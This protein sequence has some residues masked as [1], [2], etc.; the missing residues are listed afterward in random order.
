VTEA[1]RDDGD[2]SYRTQA[3]G[4]L[5]RK[6]S[7]HSEEVHVG[8]DV[9]E[10]GVLGL[11]SESS[12]VVLS[13]DGSDVSSGLEVKVNLGGVSGSG[14]SVHVSGGSGVKGFLMGVDGNGVVFGGMGHV[15]VLNGQFV[16]MLGFLPG[17]F[18]SFSVGYG[19]SPPVMGFMKGHMAV[20][21]LDLGVSV[22]LVVMGLVV[23]GNVQFFKG[24]LVVGFGVESGSPGNGHS[25]SG[26]L[27]GL[28]GGGVF[29]DPGVENSS[30]LDPDV[31]GSGFSVLGVEVSV[32]SL[33]SDLDVFHVLLHHLSLGTLG[34][35]EGI[36]VVEERHVAEH[37]DASDVVF[38]ADD[39]GVH[40]GDVHV[41]IGGAG[42]GTDATAVVEATGAG[43]INVAVVGVA[44]FVVVDDSSSGSGSGLGLGSFGIESRFAADAAVL[45]WEIPLR[46]E[47][48]LRPGPSLAGIAPDFGIICT[49]MLV[50][51]AIGPARR[52]DALGS[53]S[54]SG[55]GRGSGRGSASGRGRGSGSATQF[56][57]L[58]VHLHILG[59]TFRG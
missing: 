54:A 12:E 58:S 42:S 7:M 5:T 28:N 37:A 13:L 33:S 30:E 21:D 3:E 14:H 40:V 15:L 44:D 35:S 8:L 50:S 32:G 9:A 18:G 56:A 41:T 36:T 25:A 4:G 17:K 31:V 48:P 26:D 45:L 16:H 1:S 53:G 24:D 19:N 23:S 11:D 27:V 39:L 29:G 57:E 52:V 59:I 20:A 47:R 46:A 10:A 38:V 55:R 2:Y 43:D 22:H 34:L 49:R 51:V 6:L